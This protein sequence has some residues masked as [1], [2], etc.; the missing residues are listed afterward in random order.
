MTLVLCVSVVFGA[1]TRHVREHLETNRQANSEFVTYHDVF[2]C[3]ACVCECEA[4]S[5]NF[6][7]LVNKNYHEEF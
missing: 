4:K 3:T 2:V 1:N 6:A 7:H 5:S